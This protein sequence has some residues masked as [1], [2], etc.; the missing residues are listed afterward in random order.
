MQRDLEKCRR[1]DCDAPRT[2]YSVFCD[3]HHAQ[4]LDHFG[5]GSSEPQDPALMLERRCKQ[6]LRALESYAITSDEAVGQVIDLMIHA[7]MQ[8]FQSSWPAAYGILPVS[9]L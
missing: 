7:G 5:L 3:T 8:R 2:A 9:I 1:P 4:Q 6:I